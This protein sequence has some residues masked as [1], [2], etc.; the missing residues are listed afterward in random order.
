MTTAMAG[1]MASGTTGT[2]TTET[3]ALHLHRTIAN[4]PTRASQQ[5]LVPTVARAQI[6]L[7][8]QHLPCHRLPYPAPLQAAMALAP[9]L[10]RQT[11]QNTFH[12]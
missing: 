11:L 2:E 6:P 7:A 8:L 5:A 10:L 9:H 12:R 3:A 4:N 1:G